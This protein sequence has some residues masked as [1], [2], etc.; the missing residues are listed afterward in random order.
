MPKTD[1]KTLVIRNGTLIDGSGAPAASNTAVVIE[2]NR[3]TSVGEL[4]GGINLLDTAKFEDIDATG[5]WIMPGLIDGHCH[6]S[7]GMPAV[8]GY[9]SARGTVNPGFNALRAARNAQKILR[10][11]VTSISIPG[12]TWFIEVGLR[13]AIDAGLV[14]G[15]RIYTAGRFI[16]TYGSIGDYEPSWVGTPEHTLG[17]LANDVTDMIT[18][19][20]R[21][22]KHGVDFI[23]LA[24]STWGDTQTIAR[25]EIAAV[26]EEAHRRNA[27]ISIHSRGAGSTKAAAEAGV[28]WIMH[29]DLATEAELYA[30]AEAGVRIMP[31]TTFLFEA[32]EVGKELGRS[33][34]EL[35]IIKRNAD[36]AVTVLETA[37]T[38]GVKVM[39]GTDT[40]NSPVMPYGVLHAHEAEIMVK[41][42]RY[43]PMEAIT[44]YTRDNAYV[45]GLEGELGVIEP[46]KLADVLILDADPLADIGV[47]QGG[48]HLSVVIKDGRQVDLLPQLDSESSVPLL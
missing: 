4:P 19:V 41:F 45:V 9:A 14:Q 12:G 42:G 24:D 15:P 30:V 33:D 7:F 6:L 34:E 17:I 48:K 40:G 29:A 2:G 28:D 1:P 5:Q 39:C 16:V 43:T 10:S 26:V 25:E 21:Q 27:R 46:G 23:K 13:D 44:A 35:D 22:T 32:L 18:E 38:L 20:R 47:L 37:R 11:G 8:Q 3:I 31:T 36:S